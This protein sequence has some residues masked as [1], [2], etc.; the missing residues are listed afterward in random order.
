MNDFK[1]MRQITGLAFVE[2]TICAD[3]CVV[4]N[5][6][7]INIWYI[8]WLLE[9]GFFSH[10]NIFFVQGDTQRVPQILF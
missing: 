8:L 9:T 10:M 5:K 1:E 6:N 4:Q 2:I 3:N 7:K